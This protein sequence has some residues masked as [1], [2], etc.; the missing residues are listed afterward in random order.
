MHSDHH[1]GGVYQV[2]EGKT[3]EVTYDPCLTDGEAEMMS[4]ETN[5]GAY[6]SGDYA[7]NSGGGAPS[8]FT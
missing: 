2:K 5:D 3:N 6:E 1:R 4:N 7:L 8:S